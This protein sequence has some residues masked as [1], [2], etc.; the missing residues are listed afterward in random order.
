MRAGIA[1]IALDRFGMFAHLPRPISRGISSVAP[2]SDACVNASAIAPV[3][4]THLDV[5]KRQRRT[6]AQ[7]FAASGAAGAIRIVPRIHIQMRPRRALAD[8]AFQIQRGGYAAGH[9][10]AAGIGKIGNAAGEVAQV[11]PPQRH[12]P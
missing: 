11:R 7:G 4:Y 12:P 3:S 1:Q 5:Y 2:F 9:A 6:Q 10:G 8:E